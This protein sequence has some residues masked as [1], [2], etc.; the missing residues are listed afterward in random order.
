MS[1]FAAI[2]RIALATLTAIGVYFSIKQN[3]KWILITALG[4]GVIT[5]SL[6]AIESIIQKDFTEEVKKD[7]RDLMDTV[8][9]EIISVINS[10]GMNL[11][12][13][14]DEVDTSLLI[15]E[16]KINTATES[17]NSKIAKFDDIFDSLNTSVYTLKSDLGKLSRGT[18]NLRSDINNVR[19]KIDTLNNE[20][21]GLQ[22]V[23]RNEYLHEL[24]SLPPLQIEYQIKFQLPDNRFQMEIQKSFEN[25]MYY[26]WDDPN[27]LDSCFFEDRLKVGLFVSNLEII[28]QYNRRGV[29]TSLPKADFGFFSK[30]SFPNLEKSLT[31]EQGFGLLFYDYS[32]DG[33][34]Y[35]NAYLAD[36]NIKFKQR[37]NKI[38]FD[39]IDNSI[40]V[41][42]QILFEIV[43]P[44]EW[45]SLFQTKGRIMKFVLTFKK[46]PDL[47][48][49]LNNKKLSYN[50]DSVR[51]VKKFKLSVNNLSNAANLEF[52]QTTSGSPYNEPF[53]QGIINI[54][55]GVIES[56]VK[57]KKW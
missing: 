17:Y 46:I 22:A 53:V 32:N 11:L 6:D 20:V 9:F 31:P 13:R 51:L 15:L 52:S 42:Y 47:K 21:S 18:I 27:D 35:R 4:I 25:S 28:E 43:D 29:S 19:G 7:A 57:Q 38:Y 5:I 23:V 30:K 1:L 26:N 37:I 3:S 8:T 10:K 41:N 45:R 33:N 56:F 50:L 40:D 12:K 16:E 55:E 2:L 54:D 44:P 36:S 34:L 14:M 24:T 49:R 48:L 39:P